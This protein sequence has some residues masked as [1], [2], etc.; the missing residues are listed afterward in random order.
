MIKVSHFIQIEFLDVIFLKLDL[1][2]FDKLVDEAEAACKRIYGLECSRVP[3]QKTVIVSTWRSGSTFLMEALN[4]HPTT[5]LHYE[6]FLLFTEER[7]SKT[8][9]IPVALRVIENLLNCNMTKEGKFSQTYEIKVKFFKQTSHSLIGY[10]KR[11]KKK[12]SF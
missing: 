8:E 9:D 2:H 1:S 3:V 12:I 5:F 4:S 10:P 7:I 11:I 6:P